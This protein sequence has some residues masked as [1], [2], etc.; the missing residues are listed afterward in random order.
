MSTPATEPT[1]E[2]IYYANRIERSLQDL[3]DGN[4]VALHR[5]FLAEAAVTIRQLSQPIDM[6]LFCPNCGMQHIDEPEDEIDMQCN[7]NR[8]VGTMWTNPPHRSHLCHGCGH[9]W[10]PADVPT[11]GVQAIQT[12]GKADSGPSKF[13]ILPTPKEHTP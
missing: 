7:T 9:I 13:T 2:P 4:T 5:D 1:G 8:V 10:R 11:N 6:V 12:R 3:P